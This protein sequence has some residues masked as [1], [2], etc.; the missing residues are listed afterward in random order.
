MS[1]SSVAA[2]AAR[3]RSDPGHGGTLPVIPAAGLEPPIDAPRLPLDASWHTASAGW[4]TTIAETPRAMLLAAPV[5]LGASR[6]VAGASRSASSARRAPSASRQPRRSSS[7]SPSRRRPAS[8]CPSRSPPRS[9]AALF[10][11]IGTAHDPASPFRVEFDQPDGPRVGGR[12]LRRRARGRRTRS[13]GTRRGGSLTLVPTTAGPP[14]TLYTRQV[15]PAAHGA[16]GGDASRRPSAAWSSRDGAGIVDLA[17]TMA[18]TTAVAPEHRVPH[19]ARPAGRP[20]RRSRAAIRADPPLAGDLVAGARP[21]GVFRFEPFGA[22]APDT[23]YRIWLEGLVR[24]RRRP[25]PADGRGPGPR[26]RRAGGDVRF[27]P[28][29]DATRVDAQR[30]ALGPVH[31]AD[32]PVATRPRRSRRRR[33]QGRRRAET[34]SPGRHDVLVFHPKQALPYGA[35]VDR[36]RRRATRAGVPLAGADVARRRPAPGSSGRRPS[37]RSTRSAIPTGGSGRG[38]RQLGARSRPTTCGLMNCTRTGGWV[39]SSGA[40]SSPGGRERRAA[41]ARRGDLSA[42]SRGRTRKRLA[43]GSH[44]SHFI[45]GNPGDRLRRAGYTSYRW[46]REHRLPVGATRTRRARLAPLLPE[47][48]VVQRRPLR[49][50]DERALTTGSASASGSRAAGSASSSTSTT[51]DRTRVRDGTIGP[52]TRR[53]RQPSDRAVIRNV[54]HPRRNE[55][56]LLAD[57]YELPSAGRRRAALHEPA[58]D[59]RQAAGLHRRHRRRSSSSR[60]THPVP[61]DPA[62]GELALARTRAAGDATR[63]DGG[64]PLTTRRAHDP[65]W[66]RTRRSPSPDA[67]AGRR[68]RPRARDRRGLPAAH[69]RRLTR[70]GPAQAV[71]DKDPVLHSRRDAQEPRDRRVARQGA[72]DRALPRPGLPVLASYGHVRDLP[73][74][75][76]KGKFG[77]D[78][79]HDFAPEYVI[80]DDRRKQVAD[81]REGRQAAPTT[82]T[83][84]PTSTARA[85]RSPGTSPRPPTSPPAKTQPG[86]LQRD[87]RGR[88]P[89]GVRP[90]AR[91]RH[92]PRRRA[93]GAPDR[94]PPRRLHAQPAPVAQGPRRACRPAASSRSRSGS[95]SSASARSARSP[96]ASTGR[97]RRSSRRPPATAFAADLVRID[98]EAARR[99]RRRDR[100]A[101]RRRDPRRSSRSS[102][103]GRRRAPR[104]AARRRR[105]RPRTLQQEASRKLGFSPKR[106]MSVA[107]RLYEGVDTPDGQ[108]GLITYMRTDS[109]AIAGVAMGEA[110]EVIGDRFGERYTMPKGRVYK[111]KAKGAQEAHES[112]RPT[113]LRARPG[114]AARGSSSPTSCAS[115]GSSGSA[116]SRRRWRPRSSRRPRSSWPTGRTS[117]ARRRRGRSSTAS[118]GSTPRAATTRADDEA[119]RTLP[120]A[121]RGRRHD[122][123]RRRRRPSTSPSRRRAS[124]RR[125]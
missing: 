119:E 41:H 83:S 32:G 59:G 81:D 80:S 123:S 19:P 5:V 103:Q 104:S 74:N 92:G 11:S 68:R 76:G 121:R 77:V 42:R 33:R 105:S 49:E 100:R 70:D 28:H 85:R 67:R 71:G 87:H 37:R 113:S 62:G 34:W 109:T 36:Q 18:T 56:P 102:T 30:D 40:C 27:R 25:V 112:I 65:A 10:V 125:R 21:P 2:G 58:L 50:P 47:R 96:P 84:P 7:R 118:P 16:A 38:R 43:T 15:G 79:D 101:A 66:R 75:P 122:A 86:D 13:P 44:C 72:D 39:T 99:R 63:A 20:R 110:R 1:A 93:A 120:A 98:G 73:E 91:D 64:E 115:T 12:A 116:R 3:D 117:C 46:A 14:D 106:T 94:R 97:S 60:T 51:P 82:S 69:P 8:P 4:R 89:R 48:E 26:G 17:P 108:V 24:H 95:S 57:L 78:V 9:S 22:L 53:I 31:A 107:Q 52:V 6:R 55:Q 111:T 29:D 114:L 23:D 54:V 45:G 124:P 90:S 88:D 61:R 35:K